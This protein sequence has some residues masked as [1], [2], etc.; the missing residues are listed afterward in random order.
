MNTT[1]KQSAPAPVYRPTK[2]P[3]E[4]TNDFLSGRRSRKYDGE[5][6]YTEEFFSAAG[7]IASNGHDF[8]ERDFTALT[9]RFDNG[10]GET[11]RAMRI[12]FRDWIQYL[13][14][15]KK[16]VE[17]IGGYDWPVYRWR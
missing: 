17:E 4:L 7:L 9:A 15:H 3:L 14:Q 12:I 8:A 16:L 2:S 11:T 13:K 6:Q 1:P 5:N 10:D